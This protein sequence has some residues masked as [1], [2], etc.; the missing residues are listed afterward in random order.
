MGR[1][2]REV[3]RST[4]RLVSVAS[5]VADGLGVDIQAKIQDAAR[6]YSQGATAVVQQAIRARLQQ[7]EGQAAV[8]RI[9]RQVTAHVLGSKVGDIVKDAD[10]LPLERAFRVAPAIIAHEVERASVQAL[11]AGELQAYLA[12]EGQRSVRDL[13]VEHGLLDA[14]RG[15][16]VTQVDQKAR[17]LIATPAFTQWLSATFAAG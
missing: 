8:E 15:W 4:E 1:L 5:S 12:L 6:D 14:V 16:A 9:A 11:I 2:T 3:G 17:A 7:P 13:L 10:R